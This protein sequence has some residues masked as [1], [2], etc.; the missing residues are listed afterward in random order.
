MPG[1][2]VGSYLAARL[3]QIGTRHYFMVPGDYNLVLLDQLL[4]NKNLEEIGCCNELDAAYA[5]EGYARLT[6]C[7]AVVTTM[8]VGAFSALSG[9]AGAYAER[10][11]VICVSSGYNTNDPA[12]DHLLHHSIGTRD[13]SYQWEMFKHVTCAA[14]RIQHPDDAPSMID[15]AIRTALAER[16]PAYIEIACNLSAVPCAEPGPYD[17]LLTP[18]DSSPQALTAAVN[19]AAALLD[20]AEKPVLLA[21]SRLRSSD[22]AAEAFRA[23]A[24]ALGSAVAVMPDARGLFPEDH[25]QF[26]GT[27]WGPVS[28][29]G[30]EAILDSADVILAAGPVFND[31]VT[32][33]WTGQPSADRL[34]S[35]APRGVRLP[36]AEYTNVALTEF[37]TGLADKVQANTATLSQY[38][39]TAAPPAGAPARADPSADLTRAEMWQQ[40]GHDLDEN[41]TLLVEGGDSW[42]NAMATRLPAGARFEIS[43]QWAAIGWSVPA[44][45]GYA[46]ALEPGR[47]LVAVIGDGSFQMTAQEVANMIRYGQ[48]LL[49][50]VVNNRGY[51]VESAIHDGPY[52]Y[53][54]NWDYAALFRALN[55]GDGHG[56]GLTA[57]TGGE[58]ASAL[59][60]AREHTGG[61]VLIECQI[62]HDDC[63]SQLLE[64]GARVGQANG[65]PPQET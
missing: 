61:P 27:Y 65:R 43:M 42:F 60:R 8:N 48:E 18:A 29:P 51:V 53:F 31:Y 36:G 23:L 11:P 33:G 50:I 19:R 26:I 3:E 63:S 39:R 7:G 52:N 10:L 1:F 56:L 9:V 14:V 17:S 21:G 64:W 28:S 37:L 40:L 34:I 54:K 25:P 24:E 20:G 15:H 38:R 13:F 6:G 30:C 55:A 46:M 45:F 57:A 22:G 16:K 32:V 44:A 62:P 35:A 5:A 12:A 41:T 49:V 4:S 2:T 59:R 47:R 58:L